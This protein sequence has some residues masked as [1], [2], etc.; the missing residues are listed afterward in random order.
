MKVGLAAN[1]I[2]VLARNGASGELA[3]YANSTRYHMIEPASST[4]SKAWSPIT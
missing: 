1:Y 2:G 4:W 3:G